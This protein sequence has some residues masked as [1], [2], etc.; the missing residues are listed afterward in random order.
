MKAFSHQ[1]TGATGKR[2]ANTRAGQG[3]VSCGL[4]AVG[5]K[6]EHIAGAERSNWWVGV[7]DREQ[8]S[9]GRAKDSLS[10]WRRRMLRTYRHPSLQAL[11]AGTLRLDRGELLQ[12]PVT[13]GENATCANLRL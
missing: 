11:G 1:A 4:K 13:V 9:T 10:R 5:A 2:S 8:N 7:P 3:G 6:A 12:L